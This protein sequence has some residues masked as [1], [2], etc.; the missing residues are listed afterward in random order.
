M[1]PSKKLTMMISE[2]SDSLSLITN[3]N[4]PQ[5]E[6]KGYVVKKL[7]SGFHTLHYFPTNELNELYK[8]LLEEELEYKTSVK[9]PSKAIL[10]RIRLKKVILETT[11][12]YRS[13]L[14]VTE[15]NLPVII[16]HVEHPVFSAAGAKFKGGDKSKQKGDDNNSIILEQRDGGYRVLYFNNPNGKLLTEFD[17][18]VFSALCRLCEDKGFPKVMNVTFQEILNVINV[19]FPSGGDYRNVENSLLELFQ[20]T[21]VFEKQIRESSDKMY[22]SYHHIIQHISISKDEHKIAQITFQDYVYDSLLQ[23]Q[24]FFV[25]MFLL[26]DLSSSLSRSLY[27]FLLHELKKPNNNDFYVFDFA[28]L[29]KHLDHDRNNVARARQNLKKAFDEMQDYGIIKD[30]SLVKTGPS[31]Y[32]FLVY[33]CNEDERLSLRYYQKFLVQNQPLQLS[34]LDT[35]K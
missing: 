19:P 8:M 7:E 13:S 15:G 35:P 32:Q 20:T 6:I 17:H 3:E 2:L 9:K 10:Q 27:R 30:Y 18:R 31:N 14:A 22:V 12:N 26:N 29:H 4:T 33:P 16:P 11:I 34:V 23:G 24:Y 1:N 28:T 5:D 25:N 21:I